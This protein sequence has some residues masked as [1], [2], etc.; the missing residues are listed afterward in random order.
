[1]IKNYE[2]FNNWTNL[3]FVAPSTG[4]VGY[5]LRFDLEGITV[6]SKDPSAGIDSYGHLSIVVPDDFVDD[7]SRGYFHAGY[8]LP[9]SVDEGWLIEHLTA[10]YYPVEKTE[11]FAPSDLEKGR[12]QPLPL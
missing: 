5:M 10:V 4:N 11:W 1:M 9:N 2:F 7:L 3:I 8:L 6:V 12:I